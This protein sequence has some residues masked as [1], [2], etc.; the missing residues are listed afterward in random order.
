VIERVPILGRFLQKRKTLLHYSRF[1]PLGH[2]YSPVLSDDDIAQWIRRGPSAVRGIDRRGN[3]QRALLDRLAPSYCDL[4][5]RDNPLDGL[6]YYYNNPFYGAADGILLSLLIR[7]LQPARI[8]EVGSG[9]S[10]AVM[11]DTIDRFVRV[12]PKI[13]FIEPNADRLRKLLR[14]GD[15]SNCVI[16]ETPVQ[17]VTLDTFTALQADDIL[18]IDSSHVSKAGSDVNFLLFDVLPCLRPGVWIHIHDIATDFEYAHDAVRSGIG[19]NEA[20]IVRAFLSFNSAFRIALHTPYVVSE[21]RD[22][23]AAHMPDCLK[24]TG[25]GLWLTRA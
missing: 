3:E 8:V 24:S 15:A 14:A 5:F 4:P 7:H 22:W 10:S 1:V 21:H 2:F 19:W 23:F 9:F 18:F 12:R 25:S 6:R 17:D 20:Y 11:L 13:T 16:M